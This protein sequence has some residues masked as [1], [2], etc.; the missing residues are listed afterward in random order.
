ML[1]FVLIYS[2]TNLINQQAE[3]KLLDYYATEEQKDRIQRLNSEKIKI[4]CEVYDEI[5]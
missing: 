3:F 5:K 1:V 4:I 2:V